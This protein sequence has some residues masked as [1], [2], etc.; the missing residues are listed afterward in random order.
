MEQDYNGIVR[1]K[2]SRINEHETFVIMKPRENDTPNFKNTKLINERKL[3][4]LK[5]NIPLPNLFYFIPLNKIKSSS[6]KVSVGSSRFHFKFKTSGE[7]NY[8]KIM[9]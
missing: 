1:K 2:Y 8:N 5:F 6:A 3:C 9:Y 4:Y 7:E